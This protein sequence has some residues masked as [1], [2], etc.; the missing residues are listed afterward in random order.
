MGI[1]DRNHLVM[2]AGERAL[3]SAAQRGLVIHDQDPGGHEA[4]WLIG[5]K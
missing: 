2:L 5:L 3:Q 1:G 4:A